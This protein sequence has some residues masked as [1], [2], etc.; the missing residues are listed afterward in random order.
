MGVRFPSHVLPGRGSI[1]QNPTA[2]RAVNKTIS[3]GKENE[4]HL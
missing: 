2:E 3:G 4:K 1:R